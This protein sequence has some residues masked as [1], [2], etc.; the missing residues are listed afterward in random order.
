LTDPRKYEAFER[1]LL[2]SDALEKI[3]S[4]LRIAIPKVE[5]TVKPIRDALERLDALTT[6]IQNSDNIVSKGILI[7]E[8]KALQG[9]VWGAE[10]AGWYDPDEQEQSVRN[11]NLQNELDGIEEKLN[12][13]AKKLAQKY[14]DQ[15]EAGI[16]E[17]KNTFQKIQN[18]DLTGSN[19]D[20]NLATLKNILTR[21]VGLDNDSADQIVDLIK[22]SE[23]DIFNGIDVNQ[24]ETHVKSE[25]KRVLATLPEV[26]EAEPEESTKVDVTAAES[27]PESA[28]RVL[29]IGQSD[30]SRKDSIISDVQNILVSL[31][32]L[33]ENSFTSG[34][35]DTVTK[36]AVI[37]FQNGIGIE[38]PDGKI[39]LNDRGDTWLPLK[40][41]YQDKIH[42]TTQVEEQGNR[43]Q[44]EGEEQEG[45]TD[46]QGEQ[47][48][49][50][51]DQDNDTDRNQE[52]EFLRSMDVLQE[53]E[54]LYTSLVHE[55]LIK[56]HYQ[57]YLSAV[58][59]DIAD[60]SQ[61]NLLAQMFTGATD[62]YYTESQ[63][64]I[65]G[66]L[67]EL[68]ELAKEGNGI[69]LQKLN[70]ILITAGVKKDSDGNPVTDGDGNPELVTDDIE[71]IN[72]L[73]SEI[74][75][76]GDKL[77]E[78]KADKIN[79]SL[80]LLE[81]YVEKSDG[82][83]NII[84]ELKKGLD[85]EA[86]FKVVN[87]NSTDTVEKSQGRIAA[88]KK[89]IEDA[90][91]A[92]RQSEQR[93][94][95]IFGGGGF[96]QMLSQFF[97]III[98]NVLGGGFFSEIQEPEE[99]ATQNL[100]Q[101]GI[102]ALRDGAAKITEGIYT[103]NLIL[104]AASEG[105]DFEKLAQALQKNNLLDEISYD[106]KQEY[107]DF[108]QKFFNALVDKA[109][110]LGLSKQQITTEINNIMQGKQGGELTAYAVS[111]FKQNSQNLII[112]KNY[113]TSLIG[114][115]KDKEPELDL[116]T[117]K[118]PS[119]YRGD[120][121]GSTE[122]NHDPNSPEQLGMHLGDEGYA[123]VS[124][125]NIGGLHSTQAFRDLTPEELEEMMNKQN[126]NNGHC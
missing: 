16:T 95:G 55:G 97:T 71:Y 57:Q 78:G 22:V 87:E 45:N 38:N 92:K 33:E 29:D 102:N 41:A 8:Q 56:T 81:S 60:A 77:G 27:E 69:A 15:G 34:Q 105:Y 93:E 17:I 26:E 63:S 61:G 46:E 73:R 51:L 72:N 85:V 108:S 122:Q 123:D 89:R 9:V 18:L 10:K 68:S 13:L 126:Q 49:Q 115:I 5:E 83:L 82:S 40:K 4:N 24:F 7:S 31:G 59:Q 11:F 19:K 114:K 106:N 67:E 79:K 3:E 109:D 25:Y 116:E 117:L 28:P 90:E 66:F 2:S 101:E 6:Q 47:E 111:Y 52:T 62:K 100:S 99:E 42:N 37:T 21:E 50:N 121:M 74:E 96:W 75:K 36:D 23:V 119:E 80:D 64:L 1:A 76:A 118:I 32:H 65:S 113:V 48:K 110:E 124:N 39:W 120:G 104:S 30:Q 44:T 12:D 94:E 84:A 88:E 43:T 112:D 54:E 103:Q 14:S 125:E 70:L 86:I 20:A 53:N 35:Y 58:S 107:T 98:E 91:A